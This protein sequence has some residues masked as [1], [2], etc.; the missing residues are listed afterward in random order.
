MKFSIIIPLYNKEDGIVSSIESVLNQTF[1]D[2]EVV[3]VDDGSTDTSIENIQQF[4]DCRIRLITQQN[5]GPS[6]ARN[7]GVRK[8]NGEWI[9]FLDADDELE[10]DAL[11]HFN[12]L[13]SKYPKH[14][15]F[16]C[17]YYLEKGGKKSV[18]SMFYQDGI[19]H[20]G[21]RAWFF[22]RLLPCQGSFVLSRDVAINNPYPENLRRWEDASMLFDVMR[23]HKFVRSHI[24]VFTYHLD[25]TE[26]SHRC[27]NHQVDFVCNLNPNGKGFWE[28]ICLYHLYKQACRMY[29]EEAK[30][31][32]PKSFFSSKIRIS[33]LA[34]NALSDFATSLKHLLFR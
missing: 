12:N 29:P 3:I 11:S 24:P 13:I 1:K 23:N 17:N 33:Y 14:K 5:A 8:A 27:K 32:Y 20:N 31:L 10:P 30:S 28:Q 16:A 25:M 15:C 22:A 18:R 2:F 4:D 7:H 6:A 26:G 34:I 19:V 21:Y 9:L